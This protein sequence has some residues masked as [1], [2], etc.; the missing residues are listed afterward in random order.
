MALTHIELVCV[1]AACIFVAA[2]LAALIA[3]CVR[4]KTEVVSFLNMF[5]GG[6]LLAAGFVHLM[7]DA[8][9]MYAE[10]TATNTSSSLSLGDSGGDDSFP[11]PFFACSAGVYGFLLL[12]TVVL[13][14]NTALTAACARSK[15]AR[16]IRDQLEASD[17][18]GKYD[19]HQHHRC[20][21]PLRLGAGSW[22]TRHRH[23]CVSAPVP[24]A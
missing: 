20:C 6:V 22:S 24:R 16:H 14:C 17:G 13:E 4:G 10:G 9:D 19:H 8:A 15:A 21:R 3:H 11:W 2:E 5:G 23:R 18:A 7:P 12:E 1:Y